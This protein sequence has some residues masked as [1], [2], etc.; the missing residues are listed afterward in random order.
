MIHVE[1]DA[2][3][4]NEGACKSGQP[5]QIVENGQNQIENVTQTGVQIEPSSHEKLN[6]PITKIIFTCN[7]CRNISM[8]KLIEHTCM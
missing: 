8:Y 3:M 6:V 1:T 2:I 7:S 5:D 4:L